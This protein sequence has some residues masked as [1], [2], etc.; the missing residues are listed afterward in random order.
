MSYA[1]S[2]P[3]IACHTQST[4]ISPYTSS[5]P[6][7]AQH[8]SITIRSLG[9]AHRTLDASSTTHRTAQRYHHTLAQYHT[10]H[11]TVALQYARSVPDIA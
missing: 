1:R 11:S 3:H 9:T 5:A 10:S 2:V 4:V 7:F 8:R 6:H